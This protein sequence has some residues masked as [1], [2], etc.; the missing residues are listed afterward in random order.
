[1]DEL[2][3]SAEPPGCLR[4]VSVGGD[5][6]PA[7]AA[8]R[9]PLSGVRLV[10]A[11]GPTE[12][13]ITAT[14]FAVPP[15]AAGCGHRVPIGRPLAGRAVYVLDRR[16]RPVPAGV[17]G[18]LHLG[19][20]LARGYLAR[21]A[22]TAERFVPDPLSG[23][24]C[25]RRDAGARL[26]RS[27]DLVR[28]RAA[29]EL[30][31]LG[32]IDHQ[33]KI[34][35]LRIELGEIE[36]A[37]A[38]H[39]EVREAVV[40][41]REQQVG[42]RWLVAYAVR[43]PDAELDAGALRAFV[44]E[45]L[46]AYMV[47][48]ALVFLDALPRTAAGKVDR[49]ALPE[50]G[51]DDL[52]AAA[53][54]GAPRNLLE[55][56]LAGIFSQV[57]GAAESA[58]RGLG[59]HDDFF[60]L[61]GHSLLATQL[62]SRIDRHL[63]IEVPL[64]VLFDRPTVAEMA[65]YLAAELRGER[66]PAAPPIRPRSGEA[67]APPLSFAQQRLW[68]LDQYEPGS[69]RYNIPN[70]LRL[71]G[72]L[73][74]AALARALTR[75]VERHEVLRTVFATV[76]GEPVQVIRPAAAVPLPVCDLSALRGPGPEAERLARIEARRPFDLRR[77]PVLRALLVKLA[78]T[79]DHAEHLLAVN[80]HHI[81]FDGWS[82]GVLLHELELLYRGAA[83]PPLPVQYADFAIWQ[84][85][86]L[87]TEVL[88]GELAWWRRQLADLPV[89]ELPCDRPRPALPS[90][91]G[92]A[93]SVYLPAALTRELRELGS[94]EGAT[95][96]MTLLAAFQA[97]LGI[98][99]GQDD[100]AVGTAV[101]GR[102]REEIE[103]LIGFFVN[104]L[105]LR[106]R[107][108]GD[109]G[110][111]ELLARVR[112]TALDAFTHQ[113]LPFEKLVEELD[114]ERRL[115]VN[116]LVQV[117]FVF[118]GQAPPLELAP[119]LAIEFMGVDTDEAKFDLSLGIVE[120]GDE[121]AGALEY[122]ADLFD[123]PTVRRLA[124]Q[125]RNLLAAMT[126]DPKRRLGPSDLLAAGERHQL[127]VEWND[128]RS[129]QPLRP[130]V[131]E[132]YAAQAAATPEAVALVC[133]ESG[134]QLTYRGLDRRSNRLAHR[135]RSLGVGGH[136]PVAVL[137]ERSPQMVIAL[138]AVLKAGGA[139]LP[140]DPGYPAARLAFLLDDAR[141]PVVLT[142]AHL[143]DRLPASARA[144]DLDAADAIAGESV[145]APAG[146][147]AADGLAYVMYTSGTTGTP[148]GVAIPHRAVVR[149]VRETNYAELRPREV[150][151]QL[152]AVSFD[153]ATLEIWGPLLNGGRLVLPPGRRPSLAELGEHLRRFAVS[154][155]WL[156]A[157]LF[158]QM[159]EEDPRALRDLGQL[160][161]GGDVLSVH[162]VRK[163]L[164]E[165]RS[166]T[167]IN[168]YG[169]TENTTFTSCY[170]I[171]DESRFGS[172][173]PIGR[174]IAN[175][176]IYL[177]NPR[178]E[179]VPL[180]STGMLYTGGAGL[181]SGY[182][183]RPAL[184]AAAF[185]PDPWSAGGRLYRTGDLARQLSDGRLEFLGRL[186]SQVKIRGFRIE[187]GE[188]ETLLGRHP[189]VREA[190]VVAREYA[191]P[192]AAADKRLVAYVVPEA[193]DAVP[194]DAE[195]ASASSLRTWL[196][197][198]LPEYMVPAAVTCLEALPLTPHGKVDRR[199]LP[200]PESVAG[201]LP[202]QW[203][204]ARDPLEQTLIDIWSRVL[205]VDGEGSR[206]GI[207]D[208]FFE[209]GGHS[210]LATRVLARL[211]HELGVELPLRALFEH[212][213]I[214]ALAARITAV[215]RDET[216]PAAPTL[217]PVARDGQPPLSFA[218]Q[219]LWFLDRFEPNSP[220]Y[221]IP[222]CLN[223]YGRLDAAAL[224]RAL[225]RIVDRH[226]VLRTVFTA[227]DGDPVQVIR[228]PAA[229][230]LPVCD[231]SALRAPGPEAERLARA[232][233]RRPFDLG[234]GPVLRCLLMKPAHAEHVLVANVHHVAFDGWSGGVFLRELELLYRGATP[235]A[236]PVQYADFAI[237]QRR[238]LHGEVLDRQ[239]AWW[240][241]QLAEL[242]V[243][244]LPCDRPRP[245]VQ[246]F[247]GGAE[248]L[249]L[250]ATLTRDL[251]ELGRREG[252]TPFMT[253]LAAFQA[254]LGIRSGQDD[255]AVGTA[256]AGRNLAEIEGLIGFFVNTLVLRA[257][258]SGNPDC[259][260]LLARV[261]ET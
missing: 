204:P 123:P 25:A 17:A 50:P 60:A 105:V 235:P 72:R 217:R 138:L 144:L 200:A 187:L 226:E 37:I 155:L 44:G 225:T 253:L 245:A 113:D 230:P 39:P 160:L 196:R 193:L 40:L 227:V 212:P 89:L 95:P 135:L 18:E 223:L 23:D 209:L 74:V 208:D 182:F 100:F 202:E 142:Q 122:N 119:E 201:P 99:S 203:A 126:A 65:E 75:A 131:H 167:V 27:G 211:R 8:G 215:L 115:N 127:L 168:G 101:A 6:M 243:L 53:E 260:E 170:P 88:E 46:P 20:L 48:G 73:D 256:V 241:R 134:R 38:A 84:R 121:L 133:G 137:T 87:R 93:E 234:R 51:R 237:W 59:I 69:A 2:A 82:G 233:A 206:I 114:P 219:R 80:I 118:Q 150:F 11:Y 32:R 229:V 220:R 249:H 13:T 181:A 16:G 3:E 179:P 259:R 12:A 76:D 143:A 68:F 178:L 116:P 149:L 145:E 180:G 159:V 55:E 177:L 221:N 191:A 54:L 124:G 236:L 157:G 24:P 63:G 43:R 110:C 129:A 207:H 251:N 213:T 252:T 174:P 111:R 83:P 192:G 156:T 66:A 214:A 239:L 228:P 172:S 15:A 176:R 222:T 81:A 255:F 78:A 261:R 117:F 247:R 19:G 184:T 246:S 244:E 194:P 36:A 171:R 132:L 153:A 91:R 41:A 62:V 224:A 29:G 106:G 28:W 71:R 130:L 147:V 10:N 136:Q 254:L 64:R 77:G 56:L 1:V 49:R 231:L 232:E 42:G 34:R 120:T 85:Q 141:T 186:D 108:G 9:W 250:P 154:T 183:R 67:E 97:L 26:Y 45:Q 210:L 197:E 128:T 151:L 92:G 79:P 188:I 140:I 107:L 162:H 104:T 166:T 218:Q 30:E 103:G 102:N 14:A 96:F 258:L 112:E 98:R 205:G 148:K 158:H 216:L 257:D 163:A 52:A 47:P 139:Y 175:T 165:L 190:V 70:H 164:R 198:R 189:A 248:P 169:P 21:P 7:A 185:V 195:T 94:R 161:A 240:R 173:V 146:A 86:W 33:V 35:G 242:P 109:P 199:A 152:A 4:L 5:V 57:L 22:L 125:L 31:F 58:A 90:Y 238:W 61:G